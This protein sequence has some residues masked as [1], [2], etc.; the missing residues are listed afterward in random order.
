MP[1]EDVELKHI[2]MAIDASKG[3]H[4]S[5]SDISRVN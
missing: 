2:Q 1:T 5:R 4:N 3:R